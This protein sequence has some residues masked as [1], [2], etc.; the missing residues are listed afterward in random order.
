MDKS[1]DN[2]K[3]KDRE[4]VKDELLKKDEEFWQKTVEILAKIEINETKVENVENVSK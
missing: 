1:S 3:K 2:E 4:S